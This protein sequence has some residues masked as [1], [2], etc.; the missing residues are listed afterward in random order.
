MYMAT[1]EIGDLPGSAADSSE[2]TTEILRGVNMTVKA[3]DTHKI[4][5]PN[6]F[7]GSAFAYAVG[8]HPRYKLTSGPS[9]RTVRTCPGSRRWACGGT[10]WTYVTLP[11]SCSPRP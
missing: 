9:G 11:T 5:G 7:G 2:G 6:G 4:M 8:G 10:T 3:G 1:L